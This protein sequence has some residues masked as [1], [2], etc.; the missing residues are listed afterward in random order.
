MGTASQGLNPARRRRAPALAAAAILALAAGGCGPGSPQDDTVSASPAETTYSGPLARGGGESVAPSTYG[1]DAALDALWDACDSGD[2][3]A[4][5][6]LYFESP[7]DS[8]YESFGATCGDTAGWGA[9]TGDGA[10]PT[11]ESGGAATTGWWAAAERVCASLHASR[12]RAD[13]ARDYDDDMM[14]YHNWRSDLL[15]R[16]AQELAGIG[17]APADG[18]LL[19]EEISRHAQLDAE[20]VLIYNEHPIFSNRLDEINADTP[21][22]AASIQ[23]RAQAGGAPSCGA[24]TM[25]DAG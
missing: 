20:A 15:D 17:G 8:D 25:G 16:A 1:D 4:C 3:Q 14:L 7:V 11:S 13:N 23:A 6:E 18:Q 10:L 12:G 24:L 2:V 21:Q 19:I 9:C 5:T 22:L